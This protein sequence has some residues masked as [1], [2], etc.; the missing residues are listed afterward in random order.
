MKSNEWVKQVMLTMLD[1]R[2]DGKSPLKWRKGF[3]LLELMIAL[4]ILAIALVPVAYFYSKSLQTVEQASIRTRALTLARE[5][6]AEIRQMPYDEIRTN[7]T[8]SP[9]QVHIYG[10][11]P[12]GAAIMVTG[13]TNA[14][15]WYGY[16]FTSPGA[17]ATH[18]ENRWAGMFLFPL[19][20]YFNPYCP[21]YTNLTGT[22][23]WSQG[24][25]NAQGVAHYFPNN[26]TGNNQVNFYNPTSINYEYEPIGFYTQKVYNT[27]KMLVPADRRDI[28]RSDRRTITGIEPSLDGANDFFRTGS[29]QQVSN[30]EIYGRRTIILDVTPDPLDT[31]GD[32]FA[33]DS[34]RDG[35]AT[36]ANPYPPAKGPDNKFQ[37]KTRNLGRG[38]L[39]IV[40]VFWLPR[41]APAEYIPS[42]DLNKIELKTFISV[43]NEATE[44]PTANGT[45]I[46]NDYL[47]ITQP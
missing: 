40:Q 45:L 47:F 27:N 35:G 44:L 13:G 5:R 29:D 8:P 10:D 37:V 18:P 2:A 16:D 4:T 42:K 33:P 25:N 14:A 41:N 36:A 1:A 43:N 9:S 28:R 12:G 26:P 22:A 11:G 19:P 24:Y 7:I 15:D 17:N 31:D 32:G 38:K 34:E 20:L 46:N 39:V 3:S 21:E 23:A 30:Y 6:L